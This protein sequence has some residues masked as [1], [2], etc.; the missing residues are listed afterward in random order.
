MA[1]TVV[2]MA[3]GDNSY[4]VEIERNKSIRISGTHWGKPCDTSFALGDTAEYDSYNLH[5]L[6]EITSITDKTVTIVGRFTKR[7]KRLKLKEFVWRNA[8]FNL[9]AISQQNALTSMSI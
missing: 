6:G 5:Y 3:W 1:K 8:N 7:A 2:E 9:E 4:K